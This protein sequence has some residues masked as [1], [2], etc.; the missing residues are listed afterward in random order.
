MKRTKLPTLDLFEDANRQESPP[1]KTTTI[2]L[3][4]TDAEVEIQE[5]IKQRRRKTAIPRT[6][7]GSLDWKRFLPVILTSRPEGMPFDVYK[8]ALRDQS[9]RLKMG[10]RL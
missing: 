5:G 8:Q 7:E 4:I 6:E 3:K 2:P 10:K 1:A 9:K